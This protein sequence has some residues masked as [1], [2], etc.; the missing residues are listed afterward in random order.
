LWDG[1]S[2]GFWDLCVIEISEKGYGRSDLGTSLGEEIRLISIRSL[3]T[4]IPWRRNAM[5]AKKIMKD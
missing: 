1:V 3:E 2:E 5:A 4:I